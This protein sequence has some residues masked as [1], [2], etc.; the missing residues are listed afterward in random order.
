MNLTIPYFAVR[1]NDAMSLA[2]MAAKV[3]KAIG[4]RLTEGEYHKL[5]GARGV[6]LGM[7]VG[8]YEWGGVRG[9]TFRFEG[10]VESSAFVEFMRDKSV[11]VI[12]LDLSQAVADVLTVETGTSWRIPTAEDFAAEKIYGDELER[13]FASEP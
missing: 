6:L 9:R 2:E 12:A 4:C 5:P 13:R 11:Q 8:L 1:C 7:D 10:E 3:S